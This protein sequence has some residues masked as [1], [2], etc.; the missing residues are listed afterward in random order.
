[1][2]RQLDESNSERTSSRS[3]IVVL[4]CLSNAKAGEA[5]QRL[6]KANRKGCSTPCRLN[7]QTLLSA[8]LATH[9]CAANSA[10]GA[11]SRANPAL[12]RLDH[13]PDHAVQRGKARRA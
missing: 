2:R 7:P 8:F 11:Y 13:R 12:Q 6:V 1:M 10:S 9:R 5:A 3:W 4:Y